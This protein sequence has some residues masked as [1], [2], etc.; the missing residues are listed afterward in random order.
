MHSIFSMLV[1][2]IYSDLVFFSLLLRRFN[3]PSSLGCI[4]PLLARFAGARIYR[5][6]CPFGAS[7]SMHLFLVLQLYMAIFVECITI[8][9]R[10]T[11]QLPHFIHP[12]SVMCTIS[13]AK[14]PSDFWG[15]VGSFFIQ[16]QI[17]QYRSS[18]LFL[19]L[20]GE[21]IHYSVHC[22]ISSTVQCCSNPMKRL[23]EKF[24]IPSIFSPLAFHID[25]THAKN[26]AS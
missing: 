4:S 15:G 26:I 23:H 14:S 8:R 11:F 12:L 7:N 19:L 6:F 17:E 18:Q 1:N 20:R 24:F 25:Y 21:T 5:L 3:S 22:A 9:K 13:L 16:K 10:E 2:E